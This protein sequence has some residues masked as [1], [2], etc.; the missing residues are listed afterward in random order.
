MSDTPD[1][2]PTRSDVVKRLQTAE[3]LLRTILDSSSE[4]TLLA[5]SVTPEWSGLD[6]LRHLWVWDELTARCLSD[7]LGGR[8]WMLTFASEDQFNQEMVDARSNTPLADVVAGLNAAHANYHHAL[9]TCTDEELLQVGAAPWGQL[10]TRL[11]MIEAELGHDLYHLGE[12]LRA[13][14]VQ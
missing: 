8:D 1:T 6:V 11:G 3:S 9:D 14:G 10:L 5:T 4:E 12:I 2:P 7:W 13:K